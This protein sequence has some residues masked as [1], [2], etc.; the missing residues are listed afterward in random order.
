MNKS[1]NVTDVDSFET[2]SCPFTAYKMVETFGLLHRARHIAL[3]FLQHSVVHQPQ[4]F[5]D[6]RRRL[7]ENKFVLENVSS[8]D[9]DGDRAR[10]NPI[11]P[12]RANHTGNHA[13]AGNF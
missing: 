11:G 5:L 9:D 2:V 7:L 1:D 10:F 12:Q 3:I 6:G 8:H 4:A 13:I